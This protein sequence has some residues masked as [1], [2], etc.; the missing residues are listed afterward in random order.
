MTVADSTESSTRN[1]LFLSSVAPLRFRMGDTTMTKLMEA[2]FRCCA[3]LD[4][5]SETVAACVRRMDD[6]GRIHAEV[7][8]F[9]TMTHDLMA[10]SEWLKAEGVTHVAME[11]TGVF[12]KPV[13][14]ILE[15]R[16]QILLVNARHIKNVPGRK[17]DVKDCEWIAQLLQYGLLKGSFIPP[18]AQRELRDLTRMR[19]QLTREMASVAN[20]I[21]K[22][23]EDT[24]I[25]LTVVATDILGVSGRKM[26]QAL[27]AGETDTAKMA[28][29]ARGRLR[30]KIPLLQ[31]ALVGKVTEHHQFMLKMLMEQLTYLE[32]QIDRFNQRIEE[33]ARPFEKAIT[34]LIPMPG[35]ERVSAQSVIAE[36]G[37][38]MNPFPADTHLCSWA[39]LCPGNNESGGKRKSGATGHGNRWL[40]TILV[41]VAWAAS[42]KKGSYFQ[43]QYRRLAGR[44]GKKR[45]IVAV[46]HS[47]LTVTYYML[48]FERSYKDLGGDHF[49]RIARD[50][51][52][53]Y[54]TKRLESLG[55]D[56]KLTE[57]KAA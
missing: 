23:L 10:L 2:M 36:I 22:V 28:G 8:T 42:H 41:Q 4:V 49:D 34:T 24:N 3:G 26:I 43:A 54:H 53:R 15:E 16:F 25:K 38:D 29:M 27:I 31:H 35:Y 7:R 51:V 12:W 9:E 57:K 44:R 48:K 33:A 40:R 5:H 50:R 45:A 52:R 32:S 14:N 56:V 39:K 47:I 21:H 19:T 13:Y 6:L 20:R 37:P 46:A 30:N 55:Y 1:R 18:L 11:S 17:T